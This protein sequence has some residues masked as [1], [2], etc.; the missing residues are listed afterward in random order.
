VVYRSCE[1]SG[2]FSPFGRVYPPSRPSHMRHLESSERNPL[3]CPEGIHGAPGSG[4]HMGLHPHMRKPRHL[5]GIAAC[6]TSRLRAKPSRSSR[7]PISPW[8]LHFPIT[9]W[10]QWA[11]LGG[12]NCPF[13]SGRGDLNP[14]PLD[15]EKR[16]DPHSGEKVAVLRQ[17]ECILRLQCMRF[18]KN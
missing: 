14:R 1:S 4:E 6:S 13:S 2:R 10:L 7:I 17:R 15:P 9:A 5:D 18:P 12:E 16:L 11:P 3:E 8:L